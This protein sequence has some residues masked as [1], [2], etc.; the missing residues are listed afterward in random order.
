[1]M[2]YRR[3]SA[4]SLTVFGLLSLTGCASTGLADGEGYDASLGEIHD[5][6]EPLNRTIYGLNEVADILFIGPASTIYHEGMP[7]PVQKAVTRVVHNL[8]TPVFA[9]NKLLQGDVKAFG[10]AAGR[11]AINTTLGVGGVMDVA[12]KFDLQE[13]KTSFGSTLANWGMEPSFYLVLPLMGPSNLRDGLGRGVDYAMDPITWVTVT[14]EQQA[15][16]MAVKGAEIL[17]VRASYDAAIRDT[18]T[19]SMDTYAT[20]RSLYTQS[21]E[22]QIK[23]EFA[24]K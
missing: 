4:L 19:N 21:R 9:I 1:M 8:E 6:L 11:F 2:P 13:E 16:V 17:N 22:A 3:F 5:P 24:T 20:M 15:G 23:A 10:R 14:P 12:Q 7:Q 18:R